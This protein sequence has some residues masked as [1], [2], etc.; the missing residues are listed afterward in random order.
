VTGSTEPLEIKGDFDAYSRII[1]APF[2][3][4]KC[5]ASGKVEGSIICKSIEVSGDGEIKFVASDEYADIP[6]EVKNPGEKNLLIINPIR[7]R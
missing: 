7:E 4:V 1:Y 5:E 3:P 2:A 6:F